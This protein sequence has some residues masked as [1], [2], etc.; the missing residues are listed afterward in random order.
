MAFRI[1][2]LADMYRSIT[3]ATSAVI[4][5]GGV[6]ATNA[7]DIKGRGQGLLTGFASVG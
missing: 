6:N 1:A 5:T 3:D 7:D 2:V 4:S